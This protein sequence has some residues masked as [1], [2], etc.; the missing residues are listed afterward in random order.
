M[1]QK[2]AVL[3]TKRVLHSVGCC[4]TKKILI[5]KFRAPR[6]HESHHQAT[7]SLRNVMSDS[8]KCEPALYLKPQV[9]SQVPIP[10]DP[11]YY[12]LLCKGSVDTGHEIVI[13]RFH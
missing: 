6:R 8:V 2:T 13:S 7:Q 4:Q 10:P 5:L 3:F 1:Q 12:L 9:K 11:T